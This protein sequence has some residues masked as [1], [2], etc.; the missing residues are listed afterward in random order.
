MLRF[1]WKE[2]DDCI[3]EEYETDLLFNVNCGYCGTSLNSVSIVS[4]RDET[5]AA[6]QATI[7]PSVEVFRCP[8][9]RKSEEEKIDYLEKKLK[10][11]NVRSLNFQKKMERLWA[12][13]NDMNKEL[14]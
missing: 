13:I 7:H 9:C 4:N 3:D 12:E 8:E 2:W 6:T 5:E 14:K 11:A 1:T 10:E